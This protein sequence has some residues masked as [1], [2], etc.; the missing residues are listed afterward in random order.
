MGGVGVGGSQLTYQPS[1][2][3]PSVTM[4]GNLCGMVQLFFGWSVGIAWG[5][6]SSYREQA[7]TQTWSQFGP[8]LWALEGGLYP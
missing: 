5:G 8:V 4:K 7:S 2:C 6:R 3:V 1:S